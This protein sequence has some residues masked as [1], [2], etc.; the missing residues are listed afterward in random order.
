M[1]GVAKSSYYYEAVQEK[2]EDFRIMEEIDKI[3]TR[4]P[5]Y[6]SRRIAVELKKIGQVVNRKKVRRLMEKMGIEAIYQKPNLSKANKEH[7][8]YPYLLNGVTPSR[9]NQVW[10]ADITY[11]PLKGG[12]LYLA[13]VIDWYSRCIISWRIS[14]TL[15][16]RFCVE[17]LEEALKK[18]TPEIFNT[19]QGVQFTAETFTGVLEKREIKISMD[20]KGR[21]I[22]NI[23]IERFW[24]SLKYEDVYLK[25]YENGKE[26]IQGINSYILFYNEERP[27]QSLKY[28]TPVEIHLAA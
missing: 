13:A 23:F 25:R 3:Y 9:P 6:G 1:A 12:F 15:D 19:D 16:S 21:A 2:E 26:A 4:H 11:I 7:K 5:Y 24:R 20:G 28:K 22:D 14:N 18:G 10:S 17:M 27:H 8:K